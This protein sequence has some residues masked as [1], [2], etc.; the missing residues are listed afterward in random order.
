MDLMQAMMTMTRLYPWD[1]CPAK[2]TSAVMD[3]HLQSE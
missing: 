3:L 1:C 2:P